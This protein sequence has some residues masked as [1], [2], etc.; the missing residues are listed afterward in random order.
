MSRFT[1]FLDVYMEGEQADE[2]KRRKEA[3]KKAE[4]EKYTPRVDKYDK[5]KHKGAPGL[6][7]TF[8][9]PLYK[10]GNIFTKSGR[11]ANKK[12]DNE[13]QKDRERLSKAT[14]IITKSTFERGSK[15]NF[16][17]KVDAKNALDATMRHL[18]RHPEA[19]KESTIEFI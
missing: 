10:K 11:E 1:D 14:D 16:S 15:G 4:E 3:E 5:N 17:D 9:N 13:I 8:D 7:A 19:Q 12:L 18:R 2:Y 6:V